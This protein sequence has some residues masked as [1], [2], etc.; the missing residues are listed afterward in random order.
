MA[1]SNNNLTAVLQDTANAIKA[2]K[3]DQTAICPRDFADEITNLPSGPSLEDGLYEVDNGEATNLKSTIVN[4][5]VNG[6]VEAK[7]QGFYPLT[8]LYFEGSVGGGLGILNYDAPNVS[9]SGQGDTFN[10]LWGDKTWSDPEFFGF[11][12]FKLGNYITNGKYYHVEM[13]NAQGPLVEIPTP[14]TP[15][16]TLSLTKCTSFVASFDVKEYAI[17]N[18]QAA[19]IAVDT[20]SSYERRAFLKH[21]GDGFHAYVPV[22]PYDYS[23]EGGTINLQ[24]NSTEDYPIFKVDCHGSDYDGDWTA[25]VGTIIVDATSEY[26][27]KKSVA[28]GIVKNEGFFYNVTNCSLMVVVDKAPW[29]FDPTKSQILSCITNQLGVNFY[30]NMVLVD[31][32]GNRL[33]KDGIYENDIGLRVYHTEP[34]S[35]SNNNGEYSY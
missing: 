7:G 22:D 17:V 2:K 18:V 8:K 32:L 35:S 1:R 34:S 21:F 25:T 13:S 11:K 6:H 20:N 30:G 28:V 19:F 33:R 3:E 23:I 16:G 15:S 31:A 5:D 14:V 24:V 27:G 9:N 26:E 12:Y 4:S 10:F 29:G